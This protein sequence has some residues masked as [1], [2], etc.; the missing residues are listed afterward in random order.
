MMCLAVLYLP[1][2]NPGLAAQITVIRDRRWQIFLSG[3]GTVVLT[4]FLAVHTWKDLTADVAAW[5]FRSTPLWILVMAG[6]SL[7][8]L[9]ELKRLRREGVDTDEVF[10]RLPAE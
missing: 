5:Y 7:F 3:T 1:R 9:R 6:A 4:L 8:F 10:S 2:K